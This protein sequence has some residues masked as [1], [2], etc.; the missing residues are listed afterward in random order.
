MCKGKQPFLCARSCLWVSDFPQ[1]R[2]P[3]GWKLR[4]WIG[5][6]DESVGVESFFDT[7]PSY[8]NEGETAGEATVLVNSDVVAFQETCFPQ[9]AFSTINVFVIRVARKKYTQVDTPNWIGERKAAKMSADVWVLLLHVQCQYEH[10]W[11]RINEVQWSWKSIVVL[12]NFWANLL[13]CRI[14]DGP[15]W[16]KSPKWPH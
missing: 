1:S 3:S 10:T 9:D 5:R 11:L 7:H 4:K 2:E 15:C 8:S 12:L 14:Q 6:K 13:G 16:Q